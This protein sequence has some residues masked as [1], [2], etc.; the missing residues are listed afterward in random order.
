MVA[1][2]VADIVCPPTDFIICNTPLDDSKTRQFAQNLYNNPAHRTL[3][4]LLN[5]GS[6]VQKT[7]R[8]ANIAAFQ[9]TKNTKWSFFDSISISYNKP[10]SCSNSRLLSLSE[11][12]VLFYKGSQAPSPSKTAWASEKEYTNATNEWVLLPVKEETELTGLEYTYYQKFCWELVML[13]LSL[14][15]PMQYN[16]FVYSAVDSQKQLTKGEVLSLGYF[17]DYMNTHCQLIVSNEK[18]AFE[19]SKILKNH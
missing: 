11:P 17:C 7:I 12:G 10:A 5:R 15:S 8:M 6:R 18:E 19:V 3:V 2:S 14:A 16:R 1:Q 9:A 13:M 4:L